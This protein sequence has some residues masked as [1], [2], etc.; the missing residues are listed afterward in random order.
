MSY[1]LLPFPG[2]HL[3][4]AGGVQPAHR[5]AQVGDGGG[6]GERQA[7][8]RGHHGHAEQVRRGGVPGEVRHLRL[9]PAQPALLPLPVRPH[10]PLRLPAAGGRHAPLRARAHQ[11]GG[12][13]EEAGQRERHRQA[14]APAEGGGLGQFGN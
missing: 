6:H 8:P 7:H 5:G 3:Q 4:L 9:P 1:I 14:A 10:V 13:A 11:A 2:G 12:A